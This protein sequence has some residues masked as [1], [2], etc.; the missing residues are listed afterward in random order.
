MGEA[1]LVITVDIPIG[2]LN[3]PRRG[4]RDCDREARRILGRGRQSSV[5]TPPTRRAL[6]AQTYRQ[7]IRLNGQGM[8]QQA[9]GI[10]AKI[11][12]VDRVMSPTLQ[13]VI[14]EAHPE[15]AFA[16]LA[17]ASMEQNK[18][19]RSGR[20]ERER[21]LRRYYGR[22][23]VKPEALRVQFGSVQVSVD[24]IV[25]AYAL[26]RTAARIAVGQATRLPR[27][28]PPCD[29]KGLRMEIWY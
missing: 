18:K 21:L 22:H 8:S 16:Q 1:P 11:R 26:A 15:L 17:G 2:L 12:E 3:T 23:Y 19:I 24:D 4:G 25:D 10:L 29:A 7:A 13:Q 14:Y 6:V 28:A 5:F 20:E 27:D 9:F